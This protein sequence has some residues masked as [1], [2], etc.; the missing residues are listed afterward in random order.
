MA[1]VQHFP[2]FSRVFSCRSLIYTSFAGRAYRMSD[3]VPSWPDT[4]RAVS[5]TPKRDRN[6]QYV[7]SETYRT[8][9]AYLLC[10]RRLPVFRHSLSKPIRVRLAIIAPENRYSFNGDQS[11]FGATGPAPVSE[12]ALVP[13]RNEIFMNGWRGGGS[14]PEGCQIYDHVS[15]SLQPAGCLHFLLIYASHLLTSY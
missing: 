7:V 5:E 6:R 13:G 1:C 3:T 11:Y 15:L 9:Y 10:N 12:K 14:S 4:I 8:Q 2:S